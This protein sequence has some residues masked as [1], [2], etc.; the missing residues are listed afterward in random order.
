M[1]NRIPEADLRARE[2]VRFPPLAL[3]VQYLRNIMDINNG[4]DI[5][6]LLICLDDGH[7][8]ARMMREEFT[9]RNEAS[10]NKQPLVIEG[11]LDRSDL[12]REPDEDRQWNTSR[13]RCLFL[14]IIEIIVMVALTL[15]FTIDPLTSS[16]A[17]RRVV[18]SFAASESGS[19]PYAGH[20][21]DR[22]TVLRAWDGSLKHTYVLRVPLVAG[23][24][25][26]VEPIHVV[27]LCWLCAGYEWLEVYLQLFISRSSINNLQ[28]CCSELSRVSAK[29]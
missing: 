1:Y 22:L 19:A 8:L 5:G 18:V 27:A 2:Q 7:A 24:S 17:A 20:F 6:A 29:Q 14:H 13:W 12:E 16:L 25:Y 4:P 15:I 11:L 28:E 10:R 21:V 3:G 26:L 9:C 23:I